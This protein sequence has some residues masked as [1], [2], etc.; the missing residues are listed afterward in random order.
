MASQGCWASS[1]SSAPI[2]RVSM[3]SAARARGRGREGLGRGVGDPR[4][5]HAEPD[6]A[7]VALAGR[8]ILQHTVGIADRHEDVGELLAQV[9]EGGVPLRVRMIAARQAGEGM[10]DLVRG[11]ADGEAEDRKWLAPRRAAW[12]SSISRRIWAVDGGA[13]V[14]GAVAAVAVRGRHRLDDGAPAPSA[15]GRPRWSRWGVGALRSAPPAG[16]RSRPLAGR[17]GPPS[18]APRR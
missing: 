10:P 1:A 2:S 18:R 5:G 6:R 13:G 16:D 12:A 9:L 7:L 14:G 3:G 8:G 17:G 4:R 11:R 15:I